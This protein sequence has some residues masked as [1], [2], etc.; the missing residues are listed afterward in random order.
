L[1]KIVSIAISPKQ[2]RDLK[3]LAKYA[4][5]NVSEVVRAL[6]PSTEEIE[7]F[8]VYQ[9][10]CDIG[11]PHREEVLDKI[12][13]TRRLF[14]EVA[15]SGH[16]QA[17]IGLQVA[18]VSYFDKT[19]KE[20]AKLF[21]IWINALRST[22]GC[23]FESIKFKYPGKTYIYYVALARNES[24]EKVGK[25]ISRYVTLASDAE[26][27]SAIKKTARV[28]GKKSKSSKCKKK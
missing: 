14:M 10:L 1:K 3:E 21:K 27:L 28:K 18:S 16:I 13:R 25:L 6:L 19:G 11:K 17:P 20:I 4:G 15:M 7:A 8:Q 26:V 2:H 22:R 5:M 24:K 9:D 23:R 12:T